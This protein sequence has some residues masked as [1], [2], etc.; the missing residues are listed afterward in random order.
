[1]TDETVVVR[2]PLD[3]DGVTALRFRHDVFRRHVAKARA[4]GCMLRDYF[5]R[6]V[7][8]SGLGDD[9]GGEQGPE[10]VRAPVP[11]Q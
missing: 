4:E 2:I 8:A 9:G 3:D 11:V 5:A 6:R 7:R 1:M 10:P